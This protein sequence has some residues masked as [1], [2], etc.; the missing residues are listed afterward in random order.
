M[1]TFNVRESTTIMD[2]G[3]AEADDIEVGAFL[4]SDVSMAPR[5]IISAGTTSTRAWSPACS[6]RR[7][8]S[9]RSARTPPASFGRRR[10]EARIRAARPLCDLF[11]W[12]TT[13]REPSAASLC[14]SRVTAPRAGPSAA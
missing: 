7:P 11:A 6:T 13:V 5:L 4:T 3:G 10:D 1:L 12:L 14:T 9:R 8:A 2:A